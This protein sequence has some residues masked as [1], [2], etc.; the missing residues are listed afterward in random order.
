MAVHARAMGDPS[1][2]SP[3]EYRDALE[4]R[5]QAWLGMSL[6]EFRERA[7]SGR[8]PVSSAADFLRMIDL[9]SGS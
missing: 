2:F 3:T 5:S 8:L 9:D 1:E 6:D 7:A 4:D